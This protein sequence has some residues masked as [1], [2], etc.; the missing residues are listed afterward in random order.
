MNEVRQKIEAF[1]QNLGLDT[2]GF[3]KCRRLDELETYY[4]ERTAAGLQNEFEANELEQRLSTAHYLENGKTILSIAFPYAYDLENSNENG[5]S[6][7]TKRLDYHRVVKSYLD[8]VVQYIESLGG[9]AVALVDSNSLPE[10][11]IAYLCG[12]GFIGKNNMLITKKYGSYVFLGEIITNLEIPC[13]LEKTREEMLSHKECGDCK[14]CLGECPTKSINDYRCNPNICLSYLTQKKELSEKQIK[15]LKGNVFG[16]DF[17]QLQCPYNVEAHP[18]PLKVFAPLPHMEEEAE[19]Y[20]Q[21]D[22][23]FFKQKIS[24]TSCGWR[25]K[26]VLKRNAM[27]RMAYEGKDLEGLRGES[28]YLNEYIDRLIAIKKEQKAKE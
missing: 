16:C 2:F 8:K 18:S 21:M 28:P 15:L 20:A 13:D 3:M 1:C 22:N 7:Y 6:I 19:V 14:I 25:G 9:Q 12:V 23:A 24:A 10:R 26:N 5:F 27:I 17:C 4:K 11:Y